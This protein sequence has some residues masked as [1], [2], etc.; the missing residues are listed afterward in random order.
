MPEQP[1]ADI[2]SPSPASPVEALHIT[3]P[4]I[5]IQDVEH[6][7]RPDTRVSNK[8]VRIEP[9]MDRSDERDHGKEIEEA[10]LALERIERSLRG[11][12]PG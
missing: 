7:V 5:D 1:E 2:Q 6:D 10:L 3:T 4:V 8:G 12:V 9:R 11:T